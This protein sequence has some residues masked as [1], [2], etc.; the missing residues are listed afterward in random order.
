MLLDTIDSPADLKKLSVEQLPEL[1]AEIRDAMLVKLGAHGGHVGPNLGTVE[2]EI[3]MHYVFDSPRDRFV[4]DVSHQSYTHKILT[5]RRE[6]FTDPAKYDDDSGYTNPNESEHDWFN[7]GH[8]STSMSLASGLAKAR[9]LAG[10]SYNVVTVI[11]DGSLSGGEAF[12]GFDAVG[13]MGTNF[14]AIVNDNEMSIAENHGGLYRGLRELRETNGESPNNLFRA[15]GFDYRYLEDGNDVSK[16]IDALRSL[17]D[18]DHPVVLHVHTLKGKG[19]A[20]AVADKETW[21]WNWHFDPKTGAST[22][23]AGDGSGDGDGSES[24]EDLTGAWLLRRMKEDPRIVAITSATPTVMGFTPELRREAGRQF[25]D[26]GIAEE[27][28][29]AMAS[30]IARGGGIP[31]YGFC[32]TFVQ[33]AYDQLMQDLCVNGNPA[34]LLAFDA[35][36]Y[37]MNDVTHLGFYDIAM[38]GN[39][40]NL[41]YLAPTCREEYFAMLEWAVAQRERPVAIRVPVVGGV[42]SHGVPDTTDYGL[43][44]RYEVARR[45]SGVAIVALGDFFQL[46][47]RV[48]DAL[49][50]ELGVKPT[51]INPKFISGVDRGLLDSLLADHRVTVTLEDGQLEGGFGEKIA[52]HYGPTAMRVKTYGVAK[53]FPDRYDPD[54]LLAANGVTVPA[55]VADVRAMLDE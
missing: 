26:V 27:Q 4:F 13:E 19:F 9:D 15:L 12:E 17:K 3:A 6:A 45:G 16:L 54:E 22:L 10:D 44:N 14:I 21:H 51:L 23:P 25:V 31:V 30:G 29:V 42:V 20:P 7:M 50:S 43:L 48:A 38:M 46:G 11:G 35:S 49:E 28:A 52:A 2:L 34:V 53:S 32:T 47:E 37:A 5:G 40:P 33:R 24:Y 8:T 1:A 36:V 55:I 39:I 41:V 18:V